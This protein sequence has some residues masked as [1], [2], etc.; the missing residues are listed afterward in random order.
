MI[1]AVVGMK[2]EAALLA[3]VGVRALVAGRDSAALSERLNVEMEGIAGL[4]SFGVAGG[5]DPS[6]KASDLV[7]ASGV[8]PSPLSPESPVR[9][10][11]PAPSGGPKQRSPKSPLSAESTRSA[12]SPLSAESTRSAESPLSPER[13]LSAESPDRVIG[14]DSAWRQRLAAAL[15]HARTGLVTGQGTP[16][17]SRVDKAALFSASGALACDMESHTVAAVA[18]RHR[19]P[20]AVVRAVSDPAYRSLPAAAVA[21]FGADGETDI[22][23]VLRALARDPRQLPALI[24]TGVEAEAAFRA[25]GRAAEAIASTL[26]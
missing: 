21:G 23:A 22:A 17:S 9:G 15:P 10:L 5:L 1:L 19:L 12:E 16:V 8:L 6:I 24:R 11:P 2:R 25:L 4:L 20:F 18:A 14:A 3:R 13:P 7:V 26:P